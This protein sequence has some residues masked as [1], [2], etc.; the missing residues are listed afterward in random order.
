MM[1]MMP[2]RVRLPLFWELQEPVGE[3]AVAGCCLLL[4]GIL[5][6]VGVDRSAVS[7][8]MADHKSGYE[9]HSRPMVDDDAAGVV[10]PDGAR[11]D[12][13]MLDDGGVAAAAG[14]PHV[15]RA[16]QDDGKDVLAVDLFQRH[17]CCLYWEELTLE[18][19]Q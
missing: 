4:L 19:I 11:L 8:R 9:E 14:E 6:V 12:K 10:V 15:L 18:K 7:R 16:H 5:P 3:A 17:Y 1:M 13:D 2:L